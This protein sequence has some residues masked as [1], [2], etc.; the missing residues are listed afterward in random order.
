MVCS[1]FV[2][3]NCRSSILT[4]PCGSVKAVD[5]RNRCCLGDLA[6]YDCTRS[7]KLG[8]I[9]DNAQT[10]RGIQCQVWGVR[11]V[12]RLGGMRVDQNGT[13]AV[14]HAWPSARSSSASPSGADSGA[15]GQLSN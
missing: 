5:A 3:W 7:W 9:G 8:T 4:E 11:P 1:P 6:T 10:V 13:K 14:P 2:V 15:S 12:H